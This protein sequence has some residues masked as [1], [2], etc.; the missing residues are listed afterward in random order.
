MPNTAKHRHWRVGPTF[1]G[2]LAA[3]RTATCGPDPMLD[4]RCW[5]CQSGSRLRRRRRQ[6]RSAIRALP[7]ALCARRVVSSCPPSFLRRS[8]APS[9][10]PYILRVHRQRGN[11]TVLPCQITMPPRWKEL[12]TAGEVAVACGASEG[13]QYGQTHIG[14]RLSGM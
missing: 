5:P 2:L 6:P 1:W 4:A 10:Q 9:K 11:A 3:R 13:T 14:E 12:S 7:L 8:K